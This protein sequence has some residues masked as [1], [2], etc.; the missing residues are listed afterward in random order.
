MRYFDASFYYVR[1]SILGKI[2]P[3]TYRQFH[4]RIW[5]IS[6]LFIFLYLLNQAIHL[7]FRIVDEIF[8][9]GYRKVQIKEPVFIISN[10][11]SGTTFLHRLISLDEENFIY[12]KNAHTFQMTASFVK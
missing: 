1:Y 10:P 2:I 9:R 6:I 5:I 7:V 8:F 12:T 11:R 4:W 3:Q